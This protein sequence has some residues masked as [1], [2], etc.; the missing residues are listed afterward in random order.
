MAEALKKEQDV[1][2]W[3]GIPPEKLVQDSFVKQLNAIQALEQLALLHAA[4]EH[5]PHNIVEILELLGKADNIPFNQ[6]Y[7]LVQDCAN[8]F[9]TKVI[10]SLA[11]LLKCNFTDRQP[12]LVNTVRALKF[13]ESYRD[14]QAKLWKVLTKY[15]R[16]PDHFH[17]LQITL[18][19]EFAPLK[20]ATSKNI[21][22]LQDTINLQQMYITSLCSHINTIYAKLVQLEKQVQTH[23][24]TDS[25]QIN[26]PEYDSD[27]DAQ[28]NTLP[29]LQT[30]A[31]NDQEEPN[32]TT[33][34]AEDPEL[35][36]DTNRT[37]PQPESVQNPAEHSLHQDTEHLSEQ[38]HDRQRS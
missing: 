8:H 1:S 7:N 13:L 19:T 27:I 21:E 11:D 28:I 4:R 34:E 9:Y 37:D 3:A 20:K 29:D 26:A 12:V 18:Q 38:H 17:D 15:D 31:K 24:Q 2:Q 23:S 5:L 36:Q 35:S 10:K 22:Q 25:V 6:L 14:K 16:L 30:H 33:G 32:P